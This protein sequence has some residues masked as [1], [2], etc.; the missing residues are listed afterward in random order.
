M[1]VKRKKKENI[2]TTNKINLQVQMF[3]VCC[4]CVAGFYGFSWTLSRLTNPKFSFFFCLRLMYLTTLCKARFLLRNKEHFYKSII[5]HG[6]LSV[7]NIFALQKCFV[8]IWICIFYRKLLTTSFT[9][10]LENFRI[11]TAILYATTK[12]IVL[13]RKKTYWFL[14]IT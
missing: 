14:F 2:I 11:H 5:L 13:F 7:E 6:H 9:L 12:S 3:C 1:C 8:R 10:I 4:C